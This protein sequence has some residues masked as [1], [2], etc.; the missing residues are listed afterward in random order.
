MKKG[1][2]EEQP[3][4]KIRHEH[5]HVHVHYVIV[6]MPAWQLAELVEAYNARTRAIRF[7][8][9]CAGRHQ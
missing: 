7:Q 5:A 1:A 3:I 2:N 6:Q 9:L 8:A 4:Q